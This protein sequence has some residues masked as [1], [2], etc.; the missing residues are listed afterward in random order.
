MKRPQALTMRWGCHSSQSCSEMRSLA[1]LYHRVRPPTCQDTISV[2]A[3]QQSNNAAVNNTFQHVV[4]TGVPA[5]LPVRRLVACAL[6]VQTI[7]SS[8]R[9]F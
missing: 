4:N 3:Y 7:L 2:L 5:C 6:G 1:R 8:S 9:T